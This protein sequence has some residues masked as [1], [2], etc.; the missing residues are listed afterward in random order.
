MR[1]RKMDLKN[2]DCVLVPL[3]VALLLVLAA[4]SGCAQRSVAR[5]STPRPV[6]PAPAPQTSSPPQVAV[7]PAPVP[8]PEVPPPFEPRAEPP[9]PLTPRAVASLRLTDEARSLLEA[10]KPDQA[11]RTLERAMNINPSNGQNF[12]YL[13]EAWLMKKNFRQAAEFNRLAAIYLKN[14]PSWMSRVAEQAER[15]RRNPQ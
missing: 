14:D 13:S 3:L 4:I 11:I 1:R 6:T 7:P 10:G 12:Y 9:Q 5:P 8:A 2:R 15:I